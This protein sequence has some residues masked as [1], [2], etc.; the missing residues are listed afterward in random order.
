MLGCLQEPHSSLPGHPLAQ[1]WG[2]WRTEIVASSGRRA[3]RTEGLLGQHVPVF[4]LLPFQLCCLE[5]CPGPQ[6]S[7]Q[8]VTQEALPEQQVM[9]SP[10]AHRWG[11]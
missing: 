11:G 3:G 6:G 7:S 4:L 5:S 9:G 1:D 8:Q 10:I 2:P